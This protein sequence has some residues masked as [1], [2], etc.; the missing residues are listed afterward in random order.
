MENVISNVFD[1]LFLLEFKYALQK[2][3]VGDNKYAKKKNKKNKNKFTIL[4]VFFQFT[5]KES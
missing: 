3:L 5:K 2:H 4:L 1:F